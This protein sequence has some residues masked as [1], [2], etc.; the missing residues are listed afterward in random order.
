MSILIFL[1]I[2]NENKSGSF[3]SEN[4]QALTVFIIETLPNNRTVYK[5]CGHYN[6]SLPR[7]PRVLNSNFENS[8]LKGQGKHPEKVVETDIVVEVPCSGHSDTYVR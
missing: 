2:K 5:T 1:S 4:L 8:L 7:E 3:F 6:N